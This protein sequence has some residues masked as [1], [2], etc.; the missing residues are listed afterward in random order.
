[1][2]LSPADIEQAL[3]TLPGWSL[4]P[5]ERG[6]ALCKQFTFPSFFQA[7]AFVNSVAEVAHR[8]DHHP[9]LSIS[10][11]RCQVTWQTHDVG[12]VTELD[13]QAAALTQALQH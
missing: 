7:M 9:D 4:V 3:A 8:L 1:M 2:K 13:L 12:A 10:Y 11:G 5:I 6:D